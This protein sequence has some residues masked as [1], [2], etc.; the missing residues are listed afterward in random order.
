MSGLKALK[1]RI[2]SV[3]STRKITKAMQ[4]V[5]AAKLRRAQD[6]THSARPYAL[7]LS[8]ILVNLSNS[9]DDDLSDMRLF[10]GTG[11]DKR[12]LLVVMTADRGLCGG[13]NNNILKYARNRIKNIQSQGKQ[14]SLYLV[15]RR[16]NDAFKRSHNAD[17]IGS[18]T[19]SEV[20]HIDFN[21]AKS[22]CDDVLKAFNDTQFD[23]CE[24]VY[25]RFKSVIS[26]EPTH[27]QIIP[28]H[29]Q[30]SVH[31]VTYDVEPSP[32]AVLSDILPKNIAVQIYAALLENS[33]GEQ[34][35]R[36]SAMDNATRNAGDMITRLTL[37]YNRTRQAN[38]T[39]ELIEI[40]SGA[41]AV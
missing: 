35:A 13:F 10:S 36:M 41:E 2:G 18:R 14:V 19:L 11:S 32:Q 23:V 40:I 31:T 16:A 12:V 28:L 38:I 30:G 34:G 37:L 3:K 7:A 33:A 22:I 6:A 15:G 29:V 9:S 21:F 24:L 39:R 20:K 4:M 17:I 5:A 8:S 25:S 26:Q 1:L 27:N